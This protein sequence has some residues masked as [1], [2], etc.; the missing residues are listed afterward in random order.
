VRGKS[1][2]KSDKTER[3][4]PLVED[5]ARLGEGDEYQMR[6]KGGRHGATIEMWTK[7]KNRNT[8][9]PVPREKMIAKRMANTQVRRLRNRSHKSSGNLHNSDF[10]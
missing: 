6:L 1:S 2:K 8:N 4:K 10:T 3:L 9:K 5:D 7:K